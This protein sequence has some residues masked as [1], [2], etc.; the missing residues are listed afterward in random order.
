MQN[1]E[2]SITSIEDTAYPCCFVLKL[3]SYAFTCTAFSPYNLFSSRHCGYFYSLAWPCKPVFSK[4]CPTFVGGVLPYLSQKQCH[5]WPI[6][7][8]KN[9]ILSFPYLLL[10]ELIYIKQT[11]K[12]SECS[13]RVETSTWYSIVILELEKTKGESESACCR[14]CSWVDFCSLARINTAEKSSCISYH[15]LFFHFAKIAIELIIHVAK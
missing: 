9:G 14:S 1:G 15:F 5:D 7:M 4:M 6:N 2:T 13:H 12:M 11:Q 3:N 8:V 10:A